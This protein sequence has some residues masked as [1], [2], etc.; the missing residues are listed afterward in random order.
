MRFRLHK[1]LNAPVGKTQ[2][3]RLE[4]GRT[5]L[6]DDLETHFLRG[7]LT[8]TRL[9]EAILLRGMVDTELTVQCIRS[10]EDFDLQLTLKLDEPFNLPFVYTDEPDRQISDDGWL[11]LTETLREEIIMSIPINPISP[12]YAN[13]Q[14]NFLPEGMSDGD[15]E[16]LT[17]KWNSINPINPKGLVDP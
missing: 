15:R 9:N 6:D 14:G 3:E 4:R 8:F 1:L 10:L 16:W 5:R 12:K 7:D 17:V 2:E 11:D 13:T